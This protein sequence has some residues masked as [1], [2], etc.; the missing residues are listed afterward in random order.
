MKYHDVDCKLF[1]L[2]S[3]TDTRDSTVRDVMTAVQCT[4]TT[5]VTTGYIWM[6]KLLQNYA[7]KHG[8]QL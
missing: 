1:G 4:E 7:T 8:C 3:A 5:L 2:C 6:G